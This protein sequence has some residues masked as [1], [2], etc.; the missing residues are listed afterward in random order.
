MKSFRFRAVL[1]IL[2]FIAGVQKVSYIFKYES[3]SATS[4]QHLVCTNYGKGV[5]KEVNLQ[6]TQII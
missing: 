5:K 3:I 6:A 4:V 1:K 2:I